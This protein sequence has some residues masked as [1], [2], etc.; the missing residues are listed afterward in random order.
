[1]AI[2][3]PNKIFQKLVALRESLGIPLVKYN[4]TIKAN[5]ISEIEIQL[6][7]D[8]GIEVSATDI[9]QIAYGSLLSYKGVLAIVYIPDT[10]KTEAYL[11]DNNLLRPDRSGRMSEKAPKFHF[12]WCRTLQGMQDKQRYDRYVLLRNKNNKFKVWAREDRYSRSTELKELV[13][14]FPCKY[15]LSGELANTSYTHQKIGY[16]G[17]ESSWN[18]TKKHEAVDSFNIGSFL[19]ENEGTFNTIKYANSIRQRPR[20]SDSNVE[21]DDYTSDFSE[22]SRRVRENADWICSKCHV[23]M[24]N[25]KE[26]LHTHHKNGKKNINAA[27]NLMVLCALCHK[28]IDSFHKQMYVKPHIEAYILKNRP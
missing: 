18:A 9:E 19:E 17:Y 13:R 5:P 23:D 20:Y 14:L 12:S 26:G 10:Y 7:T 28:G 16:K 8:G 4:H 1:M 11:K 3:N 6:E 21:A 25:K 2:E 15:C 27:G 24:S 22:I